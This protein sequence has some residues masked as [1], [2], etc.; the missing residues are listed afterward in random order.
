MALLESLA[1]VLDT[2]PTVTGGTAACSPD[3]KDPEDL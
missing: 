1:A 3:L 2:A